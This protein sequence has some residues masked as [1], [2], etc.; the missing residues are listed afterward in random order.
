MR[1]LVCKAYQQIVETGK[2]LFK[3]Y[4]PEFKDGEQ[5]R[6]FV[7]VKDAVAMTLHLAES[8]KA[9][10]LFNVG[11]GVAR[12]WVD[13]GKSISPRSAASRDRVHRD[14]REHPWAVSILH[15][16]DIAKVRDTGYDT[17]T[18]TLEDAVRGL[19]REL[20]RARPALGDEIG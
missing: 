14:A 2:S 3:S 9:G 4:K 5:M 16:R 17:E 11:S 13:L 1:S 18:T 15:L 6:D 10:G 12:T 7:Y 20:P 8:K 19:R